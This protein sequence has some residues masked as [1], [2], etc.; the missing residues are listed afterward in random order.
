MK[1][2]SKLAMAS[3]RQVGGGA[4]RPKQ[5]VFPVQPGSDEERGRTIPL[6]YSENEDFLLPEGYRP[7]KCKFALRGITKYCSIPCLLH[8]LCEI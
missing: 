6:N 7:T 3:N 5:A 1:D 4:A 2:S 8:R